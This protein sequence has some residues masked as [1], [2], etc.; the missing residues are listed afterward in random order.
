MADYTPLAPIRPAAGA[1][2]SLTS[3]YDNVDGNFT[4]L[5][6]LLARYITNNTGGTV[7]RGYVGVLSAAATDSLL[8]TTT[9]GD[10]RLVAVV[11]DVSIASAAQGYVALYGLVSTVNV[12]GAVA[13]GDQLQ[14]HTSAGYSRTGS[15][16][17]FARALT[18][19][20]S[21]NGT[22]AALLYSGVPVTP[23]SRILAFR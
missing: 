20:A 16:G 13:R 23:W 17:S 12:N 1:D 19:N 9:A 8:A 15:G 10:T 21:G 22:V 11:L 14:T 6:D 7:S 3:F 4:H 2:V 18:T 5:H